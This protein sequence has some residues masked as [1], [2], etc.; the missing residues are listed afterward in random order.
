MKI[1]LDKMYY[2]VSGYLEEGGNWKLH[3]DWVY[4]EYNYGGRN[5]KVFDTPE[6]NMRH[7]IDRLDKVRNSL[8]DT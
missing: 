3:P 1:L 7:F 2:L 8:Y 5:G 6:Q 4:C